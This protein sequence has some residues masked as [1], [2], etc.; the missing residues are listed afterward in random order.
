MKVDKTL[1]LGNGGTGISLSHRSKAEI[2]GGV[3]VG[4]ENGIVERDKPSAPSMR[5]LLGLA[6]DVPDR[7]FRDFAVSLKRDTETPE[8][9]VEK[10]NKSGL[11]KWMTRIDKGASIIQHVTAAWDAI[12]MH[13]PQ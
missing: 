2:S 11:D 6:D 8:S 1:I 9:L 5:D 4:F 7:L 3:I 10:A 13:L 12:R